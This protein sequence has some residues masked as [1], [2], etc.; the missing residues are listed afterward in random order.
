MTTPRGWTAEAP[1]LASLDEAA[2]GRLERFSPMEVPAG[3]SLFHPGDAVKGYVIVLEGRVEVR[4]AGPTGR[5]IRLYDVT[6]G[7]ACIQSTLGLLGGDDH[8]SAEAV[9]EGPCRI[10]LLPRTDFLAL[11]DGSARFRRLIL[12]ALAARMQE[13]MRRLEIMSFQPVE[14]R[15]AQALLER[16]EEGVVQATHQEL[17]VAIGSAREVISR[18]LERLAAAGVVALERGRV[19]ILDRGALRRMAENLSA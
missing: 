11:L 18:R 8:Y 15:L 4:L 6:P 5:D 10:V 16:A 19:H 1:E 12:A 7:E 13:T 9:A 3:A 17:A 2:R 14:A